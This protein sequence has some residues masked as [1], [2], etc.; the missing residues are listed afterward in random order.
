[1]TLTE[2]QARKI[3]HLARLNI[4]DDEATKYAKQLSDVL[5]NMEILQELDTTGVQPAAQVT[6]LENKVREE[7]VKAHPS[8]DELLAISPQKTEPD[9]HIFVQSVF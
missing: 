5:Q 2:E 8:P 6:G 1:M 4:S 3:A 7:N 9:G